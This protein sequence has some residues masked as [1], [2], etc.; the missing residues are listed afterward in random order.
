MPVMDGFQAAKELKDN[1]DTKD[2]K[3][4]AVSAFASDASRRKAFSV[5]CDGF[6]PKPFKE[7][8]LFDRLG[9]LLNL[10][11][12]YDESYNEYFAET[13]ETFEEDASDAV[14]TLP[15]NEQIEKI[16][17]SIKSGDVSE[18][19]RMMNNLLKENEVFEPFVKSA[20]VFIKDYLLQDLFEFIKK[21][22]LK[23]AKEPD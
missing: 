16:M 14:I 7:K 12:S 18:L 8:E 20:N 11:Y 10:E 19:K 4:I 13:A 6:L 3:I 17:L 5:G 9:E 22:Q 1:K 21:H 2:I 23:E 15:A